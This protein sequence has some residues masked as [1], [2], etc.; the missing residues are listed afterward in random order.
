MKMRLSELPM[1]G[2]SQRFKKKPVS[3]LNGIYLQ[4]IFPEQLT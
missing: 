1:A 4:I 3:K 2:K